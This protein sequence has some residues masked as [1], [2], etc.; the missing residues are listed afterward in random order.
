MRETIIFLEAGRSVSTGLQ[1][2]FA[3]HYYITKIRM[4]AL[5]HSASVHSTY[6][7]VRDSDEAMQEM[8]KRY[9]PIMRRD[10]KHGE[11]CGMMLGIPVFL[12]E[13]LKARTLIVESEP[14]PD[15]KL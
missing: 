14:I 8:F 3:D 15:D 7:S 1:S 5:V 6:F 4:A 13:T 12:D 2:A 9:D 11:Q 10:F